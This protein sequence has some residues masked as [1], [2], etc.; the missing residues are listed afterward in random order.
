MHVYSGLETLFIKTITENETKL[1]REKSTG[2]SIINATM[3]K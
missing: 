3:W 2:N 1:Q